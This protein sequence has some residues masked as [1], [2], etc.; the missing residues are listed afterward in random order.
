MCQF[1]VQ[2]GEGKK[3]YLNARNYAE[4][5]LSDVRRQKVI[6]GFF[7]PAES[8][9]DALQQMEKAHTLPS[10]VRRAI[11]NRVTRQAKKAH[12]GQVLPL[13]DVEEILGFVTSIV[14]LPCIC[15]KLALGRE[16]R[17]C[18]GVSMGQGFEALLSVLDTTLLAGPDNSAFEQLTAEE[19]R[20]AF[21]DHETEGLC[22]TVWTFGTPFI[23]GICNCDR[24]DCTAMQATVVHDFKVMFRAE[25]VAEV[26]RDVCTGCRSCMR[27]CQF[28]ALAYSAADRKASVDQRVCYGCGVC[29]S[30]CS[31][32]AISL[33]PRTDV[34]AVANV[35]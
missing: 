21:A 3:W 11:S 30:A 7:A 16:A 20:Q 2:H 23:G 18:Y 1:C 6:A 17:Y 31:K 10:F 34:P 25:Y 12:F 13:E 33:K 28:G 5:L 24:V 22:H 4:D 15:R 26:D 27:V 19:A 35:W 32:A 9:G 14:R 8:A 29:R